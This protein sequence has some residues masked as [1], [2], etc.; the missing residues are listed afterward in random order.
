MHNFTS[1]N[2]Q[3]RN[4]HKEFTGAQDQ[5]RYI[6]GENEEWSSTVGE[7]TRKKPQSEIY[8]HEDKRN[9]HWIRGER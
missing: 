4:Y 5:A 6:N 8:K 9:P 3:N 7:H 1:H 2:E